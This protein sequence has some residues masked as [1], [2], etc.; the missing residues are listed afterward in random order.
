MPSVHSEDVKRITSMYEFG[1]IIAQDLLLILFLPPKAVFYYSY[2]CTPLSLATMRLLVY[3]HLGCVQ[4]PK[5][6]VV[7]LT[8]D[9]IEA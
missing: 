4:K 3:F 2:P 1:P 9:Y 7:L 6:P 8:V 5:Q